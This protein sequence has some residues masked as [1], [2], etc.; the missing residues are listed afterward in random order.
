MLTFSLSVSNREF[1]KQ[2]TEPCQIMPVHSGFLTS[3]IIG[4]YYKSEKTKDIIIHTSYMCRAFSPIA[5]TYNSKIQ[6]LIKQYI[7]F[8]K[9]MGA[10]DILIHGP[11]SPN[12]FLNFDLGL[13]MIKSIIKSENGEKETVPRICLEIPSFTKEMH[14]LI[15][16]S[17][18]FVDNYFSKIINAGFNIVIDTAHTFNNGLSNDEVI[19]LLEKYKDHW[20]WVHLNGNIRPPKTS[21]THCPMFDSKNL[22]KNPLE[23]SKKIASF[24]KNCVCENVYKNYTEWENFA[25]E[26]GLKLISKE[27]FENL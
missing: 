27:S 16:N 26:C 11:S 25:K 18:E 14:K 10:S 1:I 23:F 24:G 20:R 5:F 21:D 15:N 6:M 17:Y 13:D 4:S 2:T 22:I 7:K 9:H 19:Q 3:S 8:A 12:E